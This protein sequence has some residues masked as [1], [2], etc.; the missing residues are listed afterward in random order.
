[1]VDY[2]IAVI[3]KSWE[4]ALEKAR[5]PGEV[6][7]GP[8]GKWFK[9]PEGGGRPVPTKNPNAGQGGGKQRESAAPRAA[10]VSMSAEQAREII[11]KVSV[12][13]AKDTLAKMTVKDLTQL[14]KDLG[15][16]ATGNKAQLVEKIVDGVLAKVGSKSASAKLQESK[17]PPKPTKPQYKL[18]PITPDMPQKVRAVRDYYDQAGSLTDEEMKD[19]ARL[20]FHR[21]NEVEAEDAARALGFKFTRGEN[22]PRVARTIYDIVTYKRAKAQQGKRTN[23]LK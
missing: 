13:E 3:R 7:Q 1:M 2:V 23:P 19:F 8:S 10:A 5:A 16:K 12:S 15:L 22:P 21:L 18:P 20:V 11:S 14:K 6:W 9:I 4:D 17:L